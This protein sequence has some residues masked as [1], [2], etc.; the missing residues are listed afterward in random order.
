MFCEHQRA[1]YAPYPTP[2]PSSPEW[3]PG[4]DLADFMEP[5]RSLKSQRSAAELSVGKRSSRFSRRWP[6][7]SS[8]WRDR[9]ATTSISNQT[10]RSAPPSRAAS[11]KQHSVKHSLAS[12]L[13][14]Q[15]T[16]SLF[17]PSRRPS[18]PTLP[19]PFG[20]EAFDNVQEPIDR[21]EHSSTPLLPPLLAELQVRQDEKVQSPLQSPSV[22][23]A[24][25][26]ATFADTPLSSPTFNGTHTPPLSAKPSLASLRNKIRSDHVHGGSA[27]GID[28]VQ[29]EYY[30]M[31]LGHANFHI[32][33]EPYLPEK[34]DEESCNGLLADW[35]TARREYMRHAYAIKESHGPTSDTYKFTSQKW[36][37]ID[38]QWQSNI[39]RSRAEAEALGERPRQ[40]YLPVTAAVSQMPSLPFDPQNPEKFPALE[41]GCVVGPMLQYA[42]IQRAPSKKKKNFLKLLL[43][44]T[45]LFNTRLRSAS[46]R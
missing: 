8:R 43:E 27:D 16:L 37:L 15:E 1:R 42:S 44:P 26:A 45:G 7:I 2:P 34:C 39:E 21:K 31:K 19:E 14:P 30:N 10:V 22:A 38:R 36:E 3:I 20:L 46:N 5:A 17:A 32:M 35:V 33:P 6:S 18:S 24:S 23:T 4:D 29:L 11:T 13:D 12:Y 41:E 28:Q 40:D 25:T 9:R